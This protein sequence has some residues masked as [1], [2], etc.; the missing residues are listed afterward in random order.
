MVEKQ[1][2]KDSIGIFQMYFQ[3]KQLD[4]RV[5]LEV[6]PH[7]SVI[8][9]FHMCIYMYLG[10]YSEVCHM[11]IYTYICVSSEVCHIYIYMYLG[12]YSEVCHMSIYMYLYVPS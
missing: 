10:L 3:F 5:F 11:C 2:F 9:M 6:V 8:E 1:W 7:N 12:V 4:C